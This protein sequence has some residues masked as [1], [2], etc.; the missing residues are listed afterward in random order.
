MIN[1]QNLKTITQELNNAKS[2]IVLLPPVPNENQV[3]AALGLH[4]SLIASGKKSQIGTSKLPELNDQKIFGL[5]QL[6]DSIGNQN[7]IINFQFQEKNLEKVD[8]DVDEQ[9]N[10][11]L[12]IKPKTDASPPDTSKI[13]YSYSGANADL[14]ITFGINSLEELGKLYSDEKK[15]LDNAKIISLSQITKPSTFATYSLHTNTVSS[16]AELV[17][18]ILNKAQFKLTSDTAGNLMQSIY[19]ATTNLTSPKVSADTFENIAFLMRHGAKPPQDRIAQGFTKPAPAPFPS[20]FPSP[21]PTFQRPI[22]PP[23]PLQSPQ[24][25][26]E[27]QTGSIPQDWQKP[28]IF[29]SSRPKN[30]N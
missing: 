6:K 15:F 7:L 18:I 19:K 24:P 16:L 12:L 25:I 9:G 30:T 17:T 21:V 28:K 3:I 13:K 22:M 23:Q 10:F 20:Q 27:S 8:Y 14:V 26:Q 29:Q 4:L 2:A 11:I 5:D 1:D